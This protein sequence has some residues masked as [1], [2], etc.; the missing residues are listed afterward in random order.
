VDHVRSQS[1]KDI[2]S[3]QHSHS[4]QWLTWSLVLC[5]WQLTKI[6]RRRDDLLHSSG[7]EEQEEDPKRQREKEREGD[8][9]RGVLFL[10]REDAI[11]RRKIV[12][13][14]HG[15]TQSLFKIRQD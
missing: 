5:D 6:K 2:D 4:S 15:R 8:I 13:R 9:L 3:V 10:C 1:R 12:G 11:L 7:E 14:G